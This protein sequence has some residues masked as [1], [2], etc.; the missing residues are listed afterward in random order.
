MP[1]LLASYKFSINLQTIPS[2]IM[3]SYDLL[4]IY[5]QLYYYNLSINQLTILIISFY[6]FY[7]T[8][9]FLYH[10]KTSYLSNFSPFYPIYIKTL[11]I[12][13]FLPY[14][15]TSKIL[16]FLCQFHQIKALI[17]GVNLFCSFLFIKPFD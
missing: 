8:Y 10:F 3:I 11:F 6:C 17:S 16:R 4:L 13:F 7:L 14:F 2:L 9:Y 5:K 15:T 1:L 12:S